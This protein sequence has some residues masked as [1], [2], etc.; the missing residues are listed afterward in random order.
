MLAV[1]RNWAR[2]RGA[3]GSRTLAV[4]G[5]IHHLDIAIGAK[6]LA[7]VVFGDVLGELFDH[8]LSAI[9]TC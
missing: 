4:H 6:D 9:D 8:D 1:F 5:H 2:R 7:D 3:I